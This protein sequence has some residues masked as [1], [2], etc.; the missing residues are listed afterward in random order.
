MWPS[1]R[2][3]RWTGWCQHSLSGRG[4]LQYRRC[5][6]NRD[7]QPRNASLH[8]HHSASTYTFREGTAHGASQ[9]V[10]AVVGASACYGVHLHAMDTATEGVRER[11][12]SSRTR[13]HAGTTPAPS[14]TYLHRRGMIS[15]SATWTAAPGRR[16]HLDASPCR[17]PHAVPALLQQHGVWRP[18]R[19]PARDGQTHGHACEPWLR[20]PHPRPWPLS[21]LPRLLG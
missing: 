16:Q 21:S 1:R 2:G 5:A 17:E 19:R 9:T 6:D 10:P 11:A 3:E 4:I 18:R 20:C 14:Q 13:T 8:R 15:S 12:A 7:S